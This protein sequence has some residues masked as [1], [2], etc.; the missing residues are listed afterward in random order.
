MTDQN[1][2]KNNPNTDQGLDDLIKDINGDVEYF[3][4]DALD[5][6]QEPPL[7]PT[8]D[9]SFLQPISSQSRTLQTSSFSS[10]WQ[11][12]ASYI[13]GPMTKIR[14]DPDILQN[15]SQ[16]IQSSSATLRSVS[17]NINSC[18][19]SA[20]SYDGQF[21]SQVWNIASE[22]NSRGNQLSD[23]FNNLSEW[24]GNKARQFMD[25]D[26][27]SS[28][29][30]G[31]QFN[32]SPWMSLLRMVFPPL[33]IVPFL[34][35]LNPLFVGHDRLWQSL[36]GSF[37]R[38]SLVKLV[39]DINK[40]KE[41]SPNQI[42]ISFPISWDK[43]TSINWYGN[44]E[45]AYKNR[46]RY[47]SRLQGLHSG[48]DFI[49]PEDTPITNSIDRTG[50]IISIDNKQYYYG[51]G[52]GN[53][54]VDYGDFLVLYGH[55]SSTSLRVGDKVEP[56][57]EIA[58]SGTDGNLA[59]LHLEVIKK[60]PLWDNLPIEK[61]RSERPGNVRTNPVPYLSPELKKFLESKQWD[62]FH[63]TENGKWISPEDQPDITPGEK[64]LVF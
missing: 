11:S 48:L 63:E 21:S 6:Y 61:K 2:A 38:G 28:T 64:Y 26:F 19:H 56:G 13:R 24:L 45:F 62:K 49:C 58:L 42:S 15:C 50:T 36:L 57:T 23:S 54:L 41:F 59:H 47:Y 31:M 39:H 18:A 53:V 52:P 34:G 20:P 30:I 46:S 33:N 10:D 17:G 40:P 29:A 55:T 32:N 1:E 44:T 12:P 4:P 7:F 25:A 22:A 43:V 9:L 3:D 8:F 14:V 37:N 27:A 60:D 16:E 51:A 5:N 35:L